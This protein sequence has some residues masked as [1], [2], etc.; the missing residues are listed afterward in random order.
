M[1]CGGGGDE[2]GGKGEG[3]DDFSMMQIIASCNH[4]YS[5]QEKSHPPA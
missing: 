4:D 1:M 3:G 2:E 5:L